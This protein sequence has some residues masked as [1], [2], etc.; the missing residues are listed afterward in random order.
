MRG[1]RGRKSGTRGSLGFLGGRRRPPKRP[2]LA[3]FLADQESRSPAGARP[4]IPSRWQPGN[5]KVGPPLAPLARGAAAIRQLRG[6]AR[7]GLPV[8]RPL[9]PSGPPPLEGEAGSEWELRATS[10]RG[11]GHGGEKRT[12]PLKGKVLAERRGKPSPGEKA[13][14]AR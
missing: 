12:P 14:P 6:R 10:P 5:G 9:R 4:G 1:A 8:E 7:R 3:T 2:S 13:P 11:G